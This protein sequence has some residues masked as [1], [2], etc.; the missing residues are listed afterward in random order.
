[1]NQQTTSGRRAVLRGGAA[2]ATTLGVTGGRRSKAAG[3]E[4]L[5]VII[6]TSPPDP[7][8]HYL[9]Y[10]RDAGFFQANGLDVEFRGIVSATNATRSVVSGIPIGLQ[11]SFISTE[12]LHRAFPAATHPE[13]KNDTPAGPSI[14]PQISLMAFASLIRHLHRYRCFICL[15]VTPAQ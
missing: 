7:A 8:C 15:N 9:Y 5:A 4:K 10:A 11:D 2:L 14:L 1:M 13:I 6:G 3:L 12:K